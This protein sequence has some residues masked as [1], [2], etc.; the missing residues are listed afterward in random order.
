[1]ANASRKVGNKPIVKS[2]DNLYKKGKLSKRARF[3]TKKIKWTPIIV[4]SCVILS[5]I[6]A[7]IFG[8]ALGKKVA[9][10][11]TYTPKRATLLCS[12]ELPLCCR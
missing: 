10:R 5:F 7:M 9:S 8:N 2:K 11:V 6:F 4:L 12:C 3:S 1:M